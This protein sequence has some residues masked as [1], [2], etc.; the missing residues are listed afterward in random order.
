MKRQIWLVT[1]ATGLV[2]TALC[3]ALLAE[4]HE[5][6]AL[7]RGSAHPRGTHPF[8][9]D[10]LSGKFPD[11]ALQ[12]VGVVVHLAA[13]SVGQRWTAKHK[14]AILNSRV[15]STSLLKTHLLKAGFAGT[16]IQASAIGIYGN[17]PAPCDENTSAGT[18]FL[19]EVARAWELASLA[20]HVTPLYRLVH[21]RLGLV[22]SP[23]G[24][25]LD[26][27][28]P[29]YKLGLGA[30]LGSGS[31]PMGWIHIDDVVQF[32]LYAA[33]NEKAHGAFNVVAPEAASNK[34]FSKCLATSLNRPHWAPAVPAFALKLAM[35]SMSSLLLEGQNATPSKL[36]QGGFAWLH[37]TLSEAL[38]NCA[39]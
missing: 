16:W 9:W 27:L 17:H 23:N 24:G 11:E 2:G 31:Q 28:L 29:I 30:P 34:R 33:S 6:R 5:V 15:Q 1:G 22:L 19:A 25:T 7:G 14:A 8:I 21:M 35:G 4:G 18:G 38:T 10:P 3:E 13:A 39:R 36:Q 32:I 12:G 20:E 26:K 37:P